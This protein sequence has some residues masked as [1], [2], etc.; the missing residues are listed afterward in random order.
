MSRYYTC[1]H[2]SEEFRLG[3]TMVRLAEGQLG[4][5]PKRGY[6]TFLASDEEDDFLHPACVPLYLNPQE[7]EEIRKQ[8]REEVEKN[9]GEA[10]MLASGLAETQEEIPGFIPEPPKRR[11]RDGRR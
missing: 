9:V 6:P 5:G 7:E 1:S 3:E 10:F 4:F 2:C 11:R 8:A